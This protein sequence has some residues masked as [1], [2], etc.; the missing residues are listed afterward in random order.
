MKNIFNTKINEKEAFLQDER[1]LGS[2][3]N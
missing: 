1:Y 2:L 3:E